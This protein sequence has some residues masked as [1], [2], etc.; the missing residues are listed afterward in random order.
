MDRG[1]GSG[2]TVY[3]TLALSLLALGTIGLIG[4]W[5]LFP[6]TAGVALLIGA[7]FRRQRQIVAGLVAGA[8]VFSATYLL[9]APLACSETAGTGSGRRPVVVTTCSRVALADLD[10]Q[11][12]APDYLLAVSLAAGAA[13][14]AGAG[15]A[16]LAS[17][18]GRSTR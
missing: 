14:V 12:R 1:R 8:V 5:G 3:L 6:L 2:L 13:V 17:R 4:G 9:T 7:P 18:V 16:L 15:I 11:P 10:R